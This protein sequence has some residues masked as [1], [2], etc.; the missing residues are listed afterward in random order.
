[1]FFDRKRKNSTCD[2]SVSSHELGTDG[3]DCVLRSQL[4]GV[5]DFLARHQALIS[6]GKGIHLHWG[7]NS[8]RHAGRLIIATVLQR[9]RLDPWKQ[10]VGGKREWGSLPEVVTDG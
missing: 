7:R 9:A 5:S 6:I 4:P 3:V 10:S 2:S 1:V 8:A